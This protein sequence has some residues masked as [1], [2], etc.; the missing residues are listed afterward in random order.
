[1]RFERYG[2]GIAKGMAL[3]LKHLFR[4]P[5][6]TQYPE[7]R[8]TVSRRTRGNELAW[9]KEKCTGCF[10]C[11]RSCPHTCIEVVTMEA[12]RVGVITAP[13][14]EECPA[15][16]D[17]ARYVRLIAEG[18]FAEALAVVRERNPFPSVCGYICAHPCETKCNRGKIDE[19]IAIRVLKRFAWEHDTRLWEPKSKKA[20]PIG[21]RVAIVGSGP[22][23]LTAGYYLAKLGHSV[24]A[25]ESLPVTGGMLRVGIPDYRLPPEI[26]DAE[27]EEIK[28]AGVEIKTNSKVES[29]DKLLEQ[30]YDAVF[31]AVG[32]HRGIRLPLPGADLE[33]VLLNTSLLKDVSLGKKVEVGKRVAVLGGGNVAFDCART[34]LRLG[35]TEVHVACLE[36]RTGMLASSEE[37]EGGEAEGVIVHP[38]HTF[39]RII[40]DD[41]HVSGVECLDVRSFE[42]DKDGKLC[43]DCIAG[44]EHIIPADTVIFAVGQVPELELVE[45][46]SD[47]K[48]VRRRTLE[49]D[50]ETLATGKK[51]IFGGGDVVTGTDTAVGAIAAGRNA[52]ISIDK[53]LGGSGD[54]DEVLAPVEEIAPRVGGPKE[55]WRPEIPTISHEQRL[56]TFSGVELSWSEQAA[57]EEATRCLRCDLAY[58]PEKYEVDTRKCIFCGLCVESCPFDALF[59][60]YEYER[61]TYRLGELVLGKEDLLIPDKRQPS[62]YARP[63]VEATLPR[64]TLLLDR[65]K[66]K[67]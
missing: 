28:R 48:T 45:G 19:P 5:I 3:T 61:S 60:G 52:A 65:D 6:T 2:I 18:R 59:M 49:V 1:M 25:F 42:F 20:P 23:G 43:V 12:G 31:V 4:K 58:E 39:T 24:T 63:E 15:G 13:C 34:S 44:S 36:C 14:R 17:A 30:G 47:I 27:I 41:G 40:G 57:I 22:A 62:G 64:Q 55:G 56:S 16:V 29:L 51:G 10:T 67:E 54:I 11:A 46:V 37:I 26:L 53:Y 8:L 7:E 32:A 38:S 66:V 21:K 35:A 9:D 33:G 50:S